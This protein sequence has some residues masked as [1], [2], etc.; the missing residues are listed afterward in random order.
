MLPHFRVKE[1]ALWGR[2]L[3]FLKLTDKSIGE[4]LKN[5]INKSFKLQV[6]FTTDYMN[7]DYNT[8][9]K[10]AM[11]FQLEQNPARDGSLL[12]TCKTRIKIS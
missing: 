6:I 1:S 3:T 10:K 12:P 5:V 4:Y 8:R 2:I 9:A 11:R 7:F